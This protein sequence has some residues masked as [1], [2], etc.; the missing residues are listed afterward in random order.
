MRCST[1]GLRG[2]CGTC[3]THP[4]DFLWR[5]RVEGVRAARH[6]DD[7]GWVGWEELK[8][9]SARKPQEDL[10]VVLWLL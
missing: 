5:Q 1:S 10:I 8:W 4:G 6:V 2:T 3:G 7:G 9:Q